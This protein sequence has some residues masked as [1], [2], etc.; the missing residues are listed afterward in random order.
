MLI[1]SV[2]CSPF[3]LNNENQRHPVV[4]IITLLIKL[5]ATHPVTN[6]WLNWWLLSA[7]WN[8]PFQTR[9]L[10]IKPFKPYVPR[11]SGTGIV[12]NSLR[13]R[14]EVGARFYWIFI[15]RKIR[16]AKTKHRVESCKHTVVVDKGFQ[17][18]KRVLVN[19][20]TTRR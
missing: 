16:M 20:K 15:V 3:R 11:K 14:N 5:E 18:R 19:S 4:F 8:T 17:I 6:N 13:I 12:F 10:N 2:F 1:F 9:W 7:E